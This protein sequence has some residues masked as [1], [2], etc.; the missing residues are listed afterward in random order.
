MEYNSLTAEHLGYLKLCRISY[1]T[2]ILTCRYLDLLGS[3]G[4]NPMSTVAK[5]IKN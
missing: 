3:L 1:N 5:S 2:T 4:Q